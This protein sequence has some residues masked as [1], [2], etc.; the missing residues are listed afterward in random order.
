MRGLDQPVSR[1]TLGRLTL[2]VELLLKWQAKTN[3]IANSTKDHIWQRHILDSIQFNRHLNG[4]LQLLD[5]GSGGGFPGV[6]LAILNADNSNFHINLVE[7]NAKK[8]AFLR[9]AIRICELN[10]HVI[11]KRIDDIGDDFSNSQMITARALASLNVLLGYAYP[12]LSRGGVG[13]FA[14]GKDFR[15]EIQECVGQWNFDL[16]EHP[17]LVEQGSVILEISNLSHAVH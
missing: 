15:H 9:Q 10:A 11:Q 17:S 7:S 16:I 6:I 8:C 5:F 13:L 2:F 4:R 3:L 14:K 1:E 12:W